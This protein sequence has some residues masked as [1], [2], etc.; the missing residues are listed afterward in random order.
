[1]DD[2]SSVPVYRSLI[3]RPVPF[4]GAGVEIG[5]ISAGLFFV[6]QLFFGIF[7]WWTG[8][9]VV[10]TVILVQLTKRWR[11]YDS[12]GV[13]SIILGA[14]TPNRY[15]RGTDYSEPPVTPRPCRP[16]HTRK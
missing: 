8:G 2:L 5:L 16:A 9:V 10:L 3:E 1:M 7:S 4:F 15:L 14:I 13:E 11:K 6:S 12:F